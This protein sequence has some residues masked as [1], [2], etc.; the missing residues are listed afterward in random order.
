MTRQ[1]LVDHAFLQHEQLRSYCS[2]PE[3]G[4]TAMQ[5]VIFISFRESEVA[6]FDTINLALQRELQK[7][8]SIESIYNHVDGMRKSLKAAAAPW[9]IKRH[10]GRGWYLEY[11]GGDDFS[12][13]LQAAQRYGVN[14]VKLRPHV[15]DFAGRSMAVTNMG[16]R[17]LFND[18][19]E[20]VMS[21]VKKYQLNIVED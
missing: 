4:L 18:T 21:Q 9:R 7:E 17:V 16:G 6:T 12:R 11:I 8:C 5:H 13:L 15:G 3:W 14:V 10:Y 1:Q 20:W 2:V 19:T